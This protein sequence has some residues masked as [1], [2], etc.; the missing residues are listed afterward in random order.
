MRIWLAPGFTLIDLLVVICDINGKLDKSQ[1]YSAATS[2]RNG[3]DSGSSKSNLNIGSM[4]ANYTRSCKGYI[5]EVAIYRH[6]LTP[7]EVSQ[8][9]EMGKP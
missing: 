8:H 3:Q 9:Y 5:D 2:L 6:A 4:N 1:S 7:T